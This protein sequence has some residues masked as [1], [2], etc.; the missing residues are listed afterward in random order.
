MLASATC[1]V[2]DVTRD[3]PII[4]YRPPPLGEFHYRKFLIGLSPQAYGSV[5]NRLII[6]GL[7]LSMTLPPFFMEGIKGAVGVL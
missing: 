3:A 6:H 4:P 1:I 2:V 7:Q 5:L